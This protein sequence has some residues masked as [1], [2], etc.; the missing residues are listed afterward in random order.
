MLSGFCIVTAKFSI[1]IKKSITDGK[2]G[3][4]DRCMGVNYLTSPVQ[5]SAWHVYL[6]K[7]QASPVSDG[8]SVGVADVKNLLP[9][10]GRAVCVGQ[11]STPTLR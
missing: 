5:S 1:Y 4:M 8:V 3:P 6:L 7:F 10:T 9:R 2:I 11:R